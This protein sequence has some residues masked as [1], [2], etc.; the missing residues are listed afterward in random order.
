MQNLIF[1]KFKNN[2]EN[3]KYACFLIIFPFNETA[4]SSSITLC[5]YIVWNIIKCYLKVV[6]YPHCSLK[7]LLSRQAGNANP[8]L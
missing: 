5:F 6:F 7:I 3:H 4:I 8:V 1:S 2:H